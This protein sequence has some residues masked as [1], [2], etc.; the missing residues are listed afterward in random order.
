MAEKFGETKSAP[1]VSDE[2]VLER[3]GY[4]QELK[5]SL[6]YF[7]AFALSFSVISVTTGLFANYGSGLQIGGPA[8]I[9]TWLIVGA[10]QLL[11]ALVFAQLARQIPLS[12]YAY[13]WTRQLAGDRLAWWAGWIMIVQFI[14]GMS[15]V[16]YA[17]ANYL[18]PY[19]GLAD[20]NRNVVAVTV[21][22]LIAI[23]LINHFGIRLSS[24]VND[25]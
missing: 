22:I 11:V 20:K 23:S 9:W 7:S 12:G 19:L 25:F 4:R 15:G 24:L 17:M 2:Q 21:A 10:G 3:F 14:A 1:V 5:R 8:F 16:C 18:I 13:Q 6:G